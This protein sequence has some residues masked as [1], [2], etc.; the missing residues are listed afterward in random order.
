[1]HYQHKMVGF[2]GLIMTN[3]CNYHCDRCE[4]VSLAECYFPTP[5]CNSTED[6]IPKERPETCLIGN[7]D[8]KIRMSTLASVETCA[9]SVLYVCLSIRTEES[10]AFIWTTNENQHFKALTLS[11]WCWCRGPRHLLVRVFHKN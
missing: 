6:E 4:H 10:E 7:G 8:L 3:Y 9:C 2:F 11:S 5:H 1:M